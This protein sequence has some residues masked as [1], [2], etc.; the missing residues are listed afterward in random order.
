MNKIKVAFSSCWLLAIFALM[1]SLQA[2]Q[3]KPLSTSIVAYRDAVVPLDS[4]TYPAL[5]RMEE[6]QGILG[7]TLFRRQTSQPIARYDFA[8]YTLRLHEQTDW[9]YVGTF[10]QGKYLGEA[11]VKDVITAFEREFQPEITQILSPPQ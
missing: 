3:A 2:D 7:C 11:G 6:I 9:S 10:S 1:P 4:W 5:Y 8:V